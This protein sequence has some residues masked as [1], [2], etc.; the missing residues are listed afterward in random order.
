MTPDASTGRLAA[1][2]GRVC[3]LL[4]LLVAADAAAQTARV[5]RNVN[6]RPTPSSAQEP[7]RLLT[8][9]EV[10]TLMEA[11]PQDGYLHVHT[12]QGD[13]G[14]VWSRNVRILSGAGEP[15][16][17]TF[18]ARAARAHA[19]AAGGPCKPTLGDCP[20]EGCQQPGTPHAIR[21]QLKRHAPPPLA[22][23]VRSGLM[24]PTSS[25]S[26]PS[27]TCTPL[28]RSMLAST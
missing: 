7:I 10:V 19:A 13:T 1:L 4:L 18:A 26:E 25:T 21:N 14:W 3:L 11:T 5:T 2:A 20:A 16:L 27:P 17:R 22:R 12:E 8:P 9:P 28:P 15:E 24:K 6:L 23:S